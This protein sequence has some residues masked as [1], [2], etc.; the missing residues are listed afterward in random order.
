MGDCGF[1]HQIS[2]KHIDRSLDEFEYRY[3]NRTNAYLFRDVLLNLMDSKALPFEKL[4][5]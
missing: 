1:Y 3:N 5:A 4:T 2:V